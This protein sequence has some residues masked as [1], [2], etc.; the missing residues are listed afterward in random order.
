MAGDRYRHQVTG[1]MNNARGKLLEQLIENS[2]RLYEEEGKA[3]IEKT[4][5]PMRV[6]RKLNDGAHF[7]CVFE[8]KGQPDF[9]GTIAGGRAVVFESKYTEAGRIS[10]SAVTDEQAKRFEQHHALGAYCFILVGFSLDSFCAIPWEIWREMKE[11]YGRKYIKC[12]EAEIIGRVP[13]TGSRILF[14]ERV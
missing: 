13:Y 10:Q 2:C 3:L 14:L 12:S 1:R 7:I 8:K 9:K 5:E 11:R 6:V 4:P